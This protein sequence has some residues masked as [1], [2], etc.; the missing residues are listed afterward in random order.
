M[1]GEKEGKFLNKTRIEI[2]QEKVI[3]SVDR[4]RR[5]NIW[6]VGV[7]EEEKKTKLEIKKTLLK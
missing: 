1:A 5:A 7:P 3:N 2:F 6:T 4:Q